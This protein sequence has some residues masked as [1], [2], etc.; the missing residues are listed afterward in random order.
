M[1][2]DTGEYPGKFL[3]RNLL[4]SLPYL[5]SR[6]R[7]LKSLLR[8]HQ[9][10]DIGFFFPVWSYAVKDFVDEGD[11]YQGEEGWHGHAVAEFG[12]GASRQ[13]NGKYADNVWSVCG[14]GV[15]SPSDANDIYRPVMLSALI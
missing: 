13:G 10:F 7:V 5:N 11:D 14:V 15:P 3:G 12:T 4:V 2:N 6:T 9:F 8:V 1:L